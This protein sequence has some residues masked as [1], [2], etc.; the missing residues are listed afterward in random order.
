M[1]YLSVCSGIEAPSVAWKPLGWEP[2]G[3]SEIGRFPNAVL[4][5]RFPNVKNYGDMNGFM[6]W[7][8]KPFDV[9]VGGTPCQSFSIAGLRNGMEDERGNLAQVFAKMLWQYRPKWFLWENVPGALFTNGGRDFGSIVGAVGQMGYWWAYRILDAQFFGVPQRRRRVYLVGSLGNQGSHEVLLH[10][11][12]CRRHPSQSKQQQEG[13]AR[14][15][16]AGTGRRYGLADE[17]I[18][19][20]GGL[21]RR[22]TPLECERLQGLPDNWTYVPYKRGWASDEPRY[23]AIGN[24]MAVPVV[25]WIGERIQRF[26]N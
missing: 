22:L 20:E 3:L 5:H 16:T 19:F 1:K 17:T 18:V 14:T 12:S 23:K 15:V 8:L 21:P 9:L 26:T 4:A 13:I 7:D 6:D 10:G 2:V 11:E 25:R 24:S